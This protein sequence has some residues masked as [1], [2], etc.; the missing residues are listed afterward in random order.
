MLREVRVGGVPQSRDTVDAAL[1]TLRFSFWLFSTMMA[2][3]SWT[4]AVK[5]SY[6]LDSDKKDWRIFTKSCSR[7]L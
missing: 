1:L 2:S 4:A 3:P 7:P 6:L 5:T